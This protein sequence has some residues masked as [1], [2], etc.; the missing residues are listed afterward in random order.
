[1]GAIEATA[2][3]RQAVLSAIRAYPDVAQ[4]ALDIKLVRTALEPVM[5]D[6]DIGGARYFHFVCDLLTIA[7]VWAKEWRRRHPENPPVTGAK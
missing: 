5:P 3:E 2:A 7:V 1:V 4:S 6:Y